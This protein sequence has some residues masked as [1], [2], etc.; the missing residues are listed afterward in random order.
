MSVS[1]QRSVFLEAIQ[2]HNP[3]SLAVVE[4]DSGASFSYGWLLQSV[5]RAKEQL[6]SRTGKT[7]I[8]GERVA[9]MVENGCDFVGMKHR[10]RRDGERPAE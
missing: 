5:T 6:L 2:R 3:S 8:S 1:I 7:N 10:V 9:F 4:S